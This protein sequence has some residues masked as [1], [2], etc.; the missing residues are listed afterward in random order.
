MHL[1][2][3][4]LYGFK[5][6]AERTE[7]L[8]NTGVTAVVGP[9]GSGKSNVS[10]AIRWVLG[11]Q[12]AR[13]LRGA[14]MEDIIFSGSD[15]RQ[16]VNY[17]EVVL[18]LD[19]TDETLPLDYAEVTITRRVFRSGESEFKLNKQACR[20]K[21]IHE[22]FMD[23]GLGREAYSIIGQGRIDEILSTKSDDRRGI[24]EEAAGV[25]K[26]KSRKKEAVRKLDE[27]E[28][29]LL[30]I[31][32]IIYE[33]EENIDPLQQQAEKAKAFHELDQQ[34]QQK[35]ISVY[36]YQ[37]EHL[38]MD[39][40]RSSQSLKELKALYDQHSVDFQQEDARLEQLKWGLHQ[41]EQQL[42]ET[43]QKLL[44]QTKEVEKLEG[45]KEVYKERKK[46]FTSN[47]RQ[48]LDRLET[49]HQRREQ[50][51][52]EQ[53]QAHKEKGRMDQVVKQVSQQ[54][55]QQQ[56]EL[57][58]DSEQLENRLERLKSEYIDLLN[59]QASVKND[60]RHLQQ[61]T[62][63][64]LQKREHLLADQNKHTEETDRIRQQLHDCQSNLLQ[65]TQKREQ[66]DTD[67]STNQKQQRHLQLAYEQQRK[68]YT[69]NF[70]QWEKLDARHR[71]LR[72][73]KEDFT[74]FFQGVKEV[75]K[76]RGEQLQGIDGAIAE[77]IRVPK[78]YEVAVETA[79]GGALQHVVVEDEQAG[80]T[81]IAYLKKR[82]L[83]RATFLPRSVIKPRT[84]SQSE[85]SSLE[86]DQGFIGIAAHL[87]D[88]EQMYTIVLSHL[89][90]H[91]V[92][93]HSLED[94]NRLAKLLRYRYRMVTLD[95]DIVNPGGSMSGGSQKKNQSN[96]LGRE[97]E[98]ELLKQSLQKDKQQL[99]LDENKLNVDQDHLEKLNVSLK[100][101][102]AESE[103]LMPLEQRLKDEYNQLSFRHSRAT[104][105]LEMVIEDI[106]RLQQEGQQSS[107][108]YESLTQSLE[109]LQE[110]ALE[111]EEDMRKLSQNK[112]EQEQNKDLHNETLTRLKVDLAGK[113]QE[114]ENALQHVQRIDN[115]LL[116]V[117]NEWEQSQQQ[118]MTLEQDDESQ[119]EHEEQL[120]HRIQHKKDEKQA[121]AAQDEQSRQERKDQQKAIENLE[122]DLKQKRKVMQEVETNVHKKEVQVNR[123]DVELDNL[124]EV[125]REEHSL[126]FELA[127][128][129]Y[130]LQGEY[131]QVK[132][133]VDSL[134]KQIQALGSVHLGAI[135]EY[136]R[137]HERF[138][139]LKA[140]EKDLLDAKT[141]LYGVIAQ[142]D[143]VMTAKFKETFEQ[144]R[145]QFHAVFGQLF[146]GG[147]ADLVLA[148][149]E[150]LLETGIDI[151]AQPP[152]KKLQH[153]A[154]LSGGERALT[155]IALLFA[156]LKVKPVPF[157]V[158]D[159]VEAA[160]DESNVV[161]FAQFLNEFSAQ[162]QFIVITHRKGTMEEA[163]VLY[164]ITMQESGVSK[165]V[166]VKLEGA[167]EII[168]A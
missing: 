159:E 126:S 135:E 129:R 103:Q 34:L 84:L 147:L 45:Q 125:L 113:E 98:M 76:V 4:E 140:Q 115:H 93:T 20:L 43:Q 19:N 27:T 75:L 117:I 70:S 17:G 12:S 55:E 160:L 143:E 51:L 112:K 154:L 74:G 88:C 14:K 31:R 39:W 35:D 122:I 49:L 96:L 72:E 1:K 163:D 151:V 119:E 99:L 56:R 165:L 33:V 91:V 10:D 149:P 124:L 120:N 116:E 53:E 18:T 69:D 86:Q 79:L 26:Y 167:K 82:Q 105:K 118:L 123:M 92:I 145:I 13:S 78:K 83:G 65:T 144:T 46:N 141:T 40:E 58:M 67:I 29:N 111:M 85:R 28:N 128:E 101:L 127:R 155:A 157:C 153:L 142:M 138:E 133:D 64:S 30:R 22:L 132:Q 130:P 95:G 21:D 121:Y 166:S 37:I 24:F 136:E 54:V 60:V 97:R 61:M 137:L 52:R 89:L 131:D 150:D 41:L 11:E 94:A 73:M 80:R 68:Q 63:Q 6:F 164:G 5:S 90:G 7:L 162:T 148:D 152:G 25:I 106:Q 38:H 71:F 102:H 48:L 66:V 57:S 100:R 156:I 77:L 9:N 139:F 44:V 59:Q 50:L 23:T 104:E 87:I 47:R 158:L 109:Q 36:V 15:T 81:A 42:D 2:S 107:E 168:S 16:A 62:G 3:L 161:R 108:R 8:F 134:K 146:E 110:Q 32:D 114:L